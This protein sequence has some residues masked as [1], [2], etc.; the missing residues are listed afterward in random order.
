MKKQD[1][2]RNPYLDIIKAI[3]ILL[4][5]I[6]HS[7]Q[8][9]SG[10][11]YLNKQLF[12]NNYLFKFIYSFHMPL[13]IMISGYLSYN[14]LNKINL[15]NTII[16]KFKSLIIPIFIW[17][18]IPFIISINNYINIKELIKLF[19]T[20]FS[21]NLWFLW[22]LFYINVLVKIINKYFKDNIYIY[23]LS[24][25]ITF[26]L[27]NTYIIKYFNFQFS[28]Y[29]FMYIYFLLGY[30]Y[31]KYNLDTKLNKYINNKTLIINTILFILLLIPFSKEYYIYTSGINIIGN[32]KQI[33][34]DLYRYILGLSG[35]IEIL[36]LVNLI[37]NKLN[38]KVKNKLLYLGK[39]TLGIYIISSIIHPF[40]LPN[41]TKNISNI[42]YLFI[43]I[44]TIIILIIS[45]LI[46]ELIKKNKFLSKYLLGEK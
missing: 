3:L 44:E 39:N 11:N 43:F 12:F 33:F 34:I 16:S 21:T 32:Y 17:S 9:G 35:S 28:L 30:F 42:N 8:Y 13:F 2:K 41:I 23:I 15:K 46:I 27:P 6:G 5:L 24:I 36:L 31:K 29:S 22:S 26:I 7:I 10:E 14:S 18:I 20:T 38:D 40:I 19:I 45:I 25:L 37:T 1:K 4:V